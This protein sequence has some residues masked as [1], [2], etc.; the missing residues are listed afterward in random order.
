MELVVVEF[1]ATKNRVKITQPDA[2][3]VQ[4]ASSVTM[5]QVYRYVITQRYLN[6]ASITRLI[7]WRRYRPKLC[8]QVSPNYWNSPCILPAKRPPFGEVYFII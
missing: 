7:L 4:N 2:Q 8:F 1:E 5:V 3:T 6:G